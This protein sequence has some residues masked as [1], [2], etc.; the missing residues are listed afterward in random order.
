MSLYHGWDHDEMWGGVE[1]STSDSNARG[2]AV[3]SFTP[4]NPHQAPLP[5]VSPLK[6][7]H[8]AGNEIF[9]RSV[10]QAPVLRARKRGVEQE[11][12][13]RAVSIA[14]VFEYKGEG[15]VASQ[16]QGADFESSFLKRRNQGSAPLQD[17][18]QYG[19]D[20]GT[21]LITP[22][23]SGKR[24]DKR[25]V[26][27]KSKNARFKPGLFRNPMVTKPLASREQDILFTKPLTIHQ[28]W[29][30]TEEAVKFQY[31]G[32]SKTTLDKLSSFRYKAS[33]EAKSQ[34]DSRLSTVI[35]QSNGAQERSRSAEI[36]PPAADYGLTD[37]DDSIV[38]GVYQASACL[39]HPEILREPQLEQWQRYEHP[40][41]DAFFNDSARN[42]KSS[43]AGDE[44]PLLLQIK[45]PQI[46]PPSMSNNFSE[47][48]DQ[49]SNY[50]LRL[51]QRTF[52]YEKLTPSETRAFVG[53]AEE[54]NAGNPNSQGVNNVIPSDHD[55][56]NDDSCVH[57]PEQLLLIDKPQAGAKIQS[58]TAIF[59]KC[60]GGDQNEIPTYHHL[61]GLD[62]LVKRRR[63]RASE[64]VRADLSD[65]SND[66]DVDEFGGDELD[67]A[68]LLAI[69]SDPVVPEP[70][71]IFAV[72]KHYSNPSAK[73]LAPESVGTHCRGG[74]QNMLAV[75]SM[76]PGMID[77][78]DEYPLEGLVE[79]DMISLPEHFGGVI[80][81]FQAPPSLQYSFEDDL[82][83]GEVY[84]SS[85]QFPPLNSRLSSVSPRNAAN[86]TRTDIDS[87]NQARV[88]D[89]DIALSEDEDWFF[90]QSNELDESN[91]TLMSDSATEL[92]STPSV[93]QV[94][95]RI[96]PLG[97]QNRPV[98]SSQLETQAVVQVSTDH[99][100][101][102]DDSHDYEP[103]DPFARPDFPE[104]V[105]DRCPIAGISAQKFLRVCF[106]VGEI[107]KEGVRCH[108]LKDVAVIELFARVKFSSREPDTTKQHFKF[109]DLWHDRPP[110]PNGMLA[111]YKTTGLAE[112]ESRV[113]IGVQENMMAR[114]I[115]RL[116]RDRKNMTGWLI[117]IINIRPTDWEEIKWTKRIVSAGLVKSEKPGT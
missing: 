11:N 84:G 95:K 68:D 33:R 14:Q 48:T 116:K 100:L 86:M 80:G 88:T 112:S 52:D 53:L 51:L 74:H 55:D 101:T 60:E 99:V 3:S 79:E 35:C 72:E 42:I 8:E 76:L 40:E 1:T 17:S 16:N 57:N 94:T 28:G 114:C 32:I 64:Y 90:I 91:A 2:A 93:S 15:D 36:P 20:R 89:I 102:I 18:E 39:E 45:L 59:S 25:A 10:A 4:I 107:F 83:P 19:K 21:Q 111:N 7:L 69:A 47:E 71:P 98:V 92:H 104:P 41:D 22:P 44:D 27:P 110:F 66:F 56:P 26:S 63:A 103:L 46:R 70:Q 117:E 115:G 108:A 81:S 5:Y 87:P 97:P 96:I 24:G 43:N 23:D 65:V 34:A 9:H 85:L 49:I 12:K 62:Q 109:A 82:M 113:F 6:V 58:D 75:P 73:S 106:R 13:R 67:D 37:R 54:I 29:T 38:N 77:L 78:D 31:K 30:S 61:A 50:D 105:L